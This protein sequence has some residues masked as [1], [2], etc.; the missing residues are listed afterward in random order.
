M[1]SNGFVRVTIPTKTTWRAGQHYFVRFLTLGLHSWTSHPFTACS[2]PLKAHLYDAKTSELIFYIR[3]QGGFTRRL[4]SYLESRP[5]FSTKV[6]LDGPYGGVD[7]EKLATP[8][9]LLFVAGGAGAGFLL[10]MIEAFLRRLSM[11]KS[12]GG[13]KQDARA[14][15][16]TARVILATRDHSTQAWFK[17]AVGELLARYSIDEPL[18]TLE[19][20]VHFT[21]NESTDHAFVS[22]GRSS[23]EV[24]DQEKGFHA[25][26]A[27]A[28]TDGSNSSSENVQLARRAS[29]SKSD[30]RPHLPTIVA[31]EAA[32][33]DRSLAIFACGPLSMQSDLSNAVAK[34][35]LSIMKSPSKEIYLHMEHFS[36]A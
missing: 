20:G 8:E 10:P 12:G 17:H 9:R 5:T 29:L 14:S 2:L 7:M 22:S 34:Q 35:Q 28:A 15:N 3:P 30:G 19:V 4:A 33:S 24:R 26:Q 23:G 31:E 21:G 16:T 1:T 32:S 25:G 11:E 36:W 13:E 6:I 18:H 27:A